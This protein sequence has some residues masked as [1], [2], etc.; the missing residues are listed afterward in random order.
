MSISYTT[1]LT[2]GNY[3]FPIVVYTESDRDTDFQTYLSVEDIHS[4]LDFCIDMGE[5]ISLIWAFREYNPSLYDKLTNNI[6]QFLV[7]KKIIG[8][9]DEYGIAFPPEIVKEAEM[10]LLE[11]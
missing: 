10:I 4:I 2:A 8:E 7:D 5:E 3:S 9:L 11:S 1:N 6:E